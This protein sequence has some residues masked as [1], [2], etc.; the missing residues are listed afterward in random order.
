MEFLGYTLNLPTDP[1]PLFGNISIFKP[2]DTSLVIKFKYPAR[3]LYDNY[4]DDVIISYKIDI[5]DSTPTNDWHCMRH[6][7]GQHGIFIHNYDHLSP[8]EQAH[9]DMYG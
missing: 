4:E 9:V 8:E 3:I 7:F 2:A 6:I 1:I 5:T